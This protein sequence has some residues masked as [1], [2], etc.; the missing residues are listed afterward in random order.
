M[1][2]PG[3][4]RFKKGDARPQVQAGPARSCPAR[5][6][7]ILTRCAPQD[8]REGRRMTAQLRCGIC[9]NDEPF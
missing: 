9:Q 6:E 4:S 3:L 2:S 5:K 7:H 1:S 8:D